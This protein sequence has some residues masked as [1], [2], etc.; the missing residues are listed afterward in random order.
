M[1]MA[2][3]NFFNKSAL[4]ASQILSGYDRTAFESC[5]MNSPVEV[6][7]DQNAIESSE[8]KASLELIVRLLTRLYPKVTIT[9]LDCV[10]PGAESNLI[11]LAKSINPD[12]EFY[13]GQPVA[14]IVIGKTGIQRTAPVFYI[15]SDEWSVRFS[16]AEPVGS[17][18]SLN[19]LAAGAAACFGAAN[20]FRQVFKD[21]L[22]DGKSD[23]SFQLSLITFQQEHNSEISPDNLIGQ[24]PILL[25]ETVLVG[26][27]AIGNGVIWALSKTPLL[28]GILY[29][30][31]PEIIDLSNL[32][33]YILTD[34]HDVGK[35]KTELTTQFLAQTA[36]K[37]VP[38]NGDWGSFLNE[39]GSWRVDTV[40]VA[41]DSAK[42]R[43]SIQGSLPKHILNAWT[44]TTDL[45][46]SR[47]FCFL[48]DACLACI[49]PTHK[50]LKSESLL[51]AESFGLAQEETQ[52]REML[53]NNSVIGQ[54][55]LEK[56][57]QGKSVPIELLN[58]Y[59][60]RPIREFYHSVFCGGILIGHERNKQV[61]TPMAFQSSLA[62][63]LLASELIIQKSGLRPTRIETMTR[64]NLLKPLTEYLNDPKLQ[65][66]ECICQ[67]H[68]FQSQYRKKYNIT[69]GDE[70]VRIV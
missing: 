64:I 3:A 34:Q 21:Q 23:K 60:G 1:V 52:I 19:P 70:L 56:I 33:R 10:T 17:G 41:V 25:G 11:D 20:L 49:Y 31:D 43:I 44:Q 18:A 68:I 26:L 50:G 32:Q 57:A 15:G 65:N 36:L 66:E 2:L 7:F 35:H 51:I 37:I 8:G 53:Y 61:E 30:V 55:W 45:G 63:I 9:A 24:S 69:Y 6:A 47:H 16:P 40:A 67:D 54:M 38:H 28:E 29:L 5:L 42:D 27:G 12:I 62:G 22:S 59:L 14:T 58:P 39:H 4:A 13:V 46:V 48:R